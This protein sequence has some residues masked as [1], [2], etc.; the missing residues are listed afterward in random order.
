MARLTPEQMEQITWPIVQLYSSIQT[1]ILENIAVRLGQ[2]KSLLD[3]NINDW[4]N[5]KL[6]QIG[7]LTQQNIKVIAKKSGLAPSLVK[8][9][10]Q[11][12][13]FK[14][15]AQNE[16]LLQ[17][18]LSQGAPILAAA[19]VAQDPAIWTILD[20][21][22]RQAIDSFNLINSSLLTSSQ[23]V[24][25]DILTKAQADVLT[26][27]KTPQ[28][29]V[30]STVREWADKGIPVLKKK[31]GDQMYAEPYVSMIIR[32]TANNVTNEMQDARFDSY[33]IDLVEI[34]SHVGARPKC[35]PYQGRIF[36]RSGRDKKYPALSSTSIGEPAGLFGIN[37]GHFQYPF[38]PGVSTQ[39]YFPVDAKKNA[40]AY[41]NSQR[42]R[43]LENNIRKAKR[44]LSMYEKM[45]DEIGIKQAKEKVLR[46]QKQIREFI[47]ETGRTRRREREQILY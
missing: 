27:L 21:F 4:Y 45:G 10:L 18:A 3:E 26:G 2:H 42:Q 15:I 9:I 32:T 28:Q 30:R 35:A 11:E 24:Y 44:E 12:A 7:G 46:R 13:G 14:G 29:A 22:E 20:A 25:I 38:V 33:G 5:T 23:Q 47:K 19:P 16:K 17:D 8:K 34:S 31:N 6:Q 41:E 39:R 37:C 40:E 36:S 1:E 43:R